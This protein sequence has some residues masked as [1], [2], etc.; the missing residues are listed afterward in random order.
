[1]KS[2]QVLGISKDFIC[3]ISEVLAEAYVA[4]HMD[5]YYNIPLDF[6][7]SIVILDFSYTIMPFGS[8]PDKTKPVI[9]GLSMPYNKFPVFKSFLESSELDK[10]CY[11]NVI[12]PSAYISRSLEMDHGILV[13]PGVILSAQSRIGFGVTIKRGSSIGHHNTIGDF[14]DINPGV[15]L[16]GSVNVGRG[17]ILGSGTV[18]MHQITIGDNCYIGSG[19]VVT[20]D[21]PPNSIA[22]GNPCKVAKAND[23]WSI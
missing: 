12:H 14:T 18:V 15:V 19:S 5:L 8:I 17:C 7:P 21:I 11:A 9:F 16:S 6:G 23:K 10:T 3:V 20:R 22:Y 13:E 1:M 2:I 4:E